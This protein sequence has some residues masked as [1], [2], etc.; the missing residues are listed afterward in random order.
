MLLATAGQRMLQVALVPLIITAIDIIVTT[1]SRSMG[2]DEV[3]LRNDSTGLGNSID[4]PAIK[5]ELFA[6]YVT[7]A[8]LLMAASGGSSVVVQQLLLR[9]CSEESVVCALALL[10]YIITAILFSIA[11]NLP[12]AFNSVGIPIPE[13]ARYGANVRLLWSQSLN[14]NV[15]G[16][17]S[18]VVHRRREQAVVV[19][20]SVQSVAYQRNF[21][22]ADYS[23]RH[24]HHVEAENS[25]FVALVAIGVVL[26]ICVGSTWYCQTVSL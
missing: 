4:E 1:T 15:D 16:A 6:S 7:S 20:Q 5:R 23:S 12:G 25:A 22:N 26:A 8:A 19:E 18:F 24:V 21:T 3:P 9:L 17:A 2:R 14:G 10:A 13:G 11:A